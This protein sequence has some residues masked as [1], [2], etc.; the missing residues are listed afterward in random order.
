MQ[1]LSTHHLSWNAEFDSRSDNTGFQFLIGWSGV[2]VRSL[3]TRYTW[4]ATN[5][6]S[7]KCNVEASR[8]RGGGRSSLLITLQSEYSTRTSTRLE[9]QFVL[10]TARRKPDCRFRRSGYDTATRQ[11]LTKVLKIG[12]HTVSLQSLHT[13]TAIKVFVSSIAMAAM[14]SQKNFRNCKISREFCCIAPTY[15]HLKIHKF[16]PE[17]LL[18]VDIK[19]IPVRLLQPDR[20]ISPSRVFVFLESQ[21]KNIS[22]DFCKNCRDE[23]CQNSRQCVEDMLNWKEILASPKLEELENK[24]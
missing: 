17:N 12:V 24:N 14:W 22:A 7:Q 5:H 18:N 6:N 15:P 19:D 20:Y 9:M 11:L 3:F 16:T 13:H 23:V 8:R 21:L 2:D 1:R 10:L 4:L